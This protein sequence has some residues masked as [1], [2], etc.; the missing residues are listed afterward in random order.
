MYK[1][2][3]NTL[4]LSPLFRVLSSRYA[5]HP[6]LSPLPGSPPMPDDLNAQFKRLLRQSRPHDPRAPW[7]LNWLISAG[8][9]LA[10]I[11]GMA[12]L[13]DWVWVA[14]LGRPAWAACWL[15]GLLPLSLLTAAGTLVGSVGVVALFFRAYG[16][17]I[18]LIILGTLLYAAPDI[19][20]DAGL[21]A[22][23]R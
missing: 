8:L 13:L 15:V 18:G 2:A 6:Q 21:S 19:L 5:C 17:G 14:L 1:C 23:C 22:L 20:A 3:I 10:I 12:T 16:P 7:W 4:D 9:W 11:S